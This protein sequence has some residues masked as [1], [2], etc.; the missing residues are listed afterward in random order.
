MI[1]VTI[2]VFPSTGPLVEKTLA[3]LRIENTME[4]DPEV[5]SYR[6]VVVVDHGHN[7]VARYNRVV[8]GF[9]RKKY[10]SLALLKL[11]LDQFS[12]EELDLDERGEPADLAR[13]LSGTSK[14]F[15]R[16]LDQ[17]RHH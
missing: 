8:S 9:Q 4:G 11:V 3:V 17:L 12:D 16:L 10:N 5:G 13:G 6:A 7:T 1:E 2:K 14:P 15:Q